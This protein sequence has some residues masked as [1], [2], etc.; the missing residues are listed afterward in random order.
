MQ[1]VSFPEAETPPELRA[2]ALAIQDDE[3]PSD[4]EN[5]H[6]PALAPLSMLLVDEGVV[7]ATLDVL[8]K[9]LDHAGEQYRASGLSAVATRR[10]RRGLGHGH[11]LVAAAREAIAGSGVD[12]ALF[13]CDRPLAAFYARAGFELLPRTVVVGGTPATPFPSDQP[14][15]DKATMG[16]FF[17]ALAR[18]RRARFDNTRIELYPGDIDKLW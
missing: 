6:D 12:L 7:L 10:D 13:T 11:R 9:R 8:T 17:S 2:Q 14:G 5:G 3:W 15:F 16:A 1:V 4:G 18:D